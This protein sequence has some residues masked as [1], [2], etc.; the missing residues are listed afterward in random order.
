MARE[1]IEF[2]NIHEMDWQPVSIPG[3]SG[4]LMQKLLS[5][6]EESGA[7]TSL[8]YI[9][10]GAT[11]EG[12]A[13]SVSIE[14]LL[15]E[16]TVEINTTEISDLTHVYI[17]KHVGLNFIQFVSGCTFLWMTE[18]A[19]HLVN[20]DATISDK[21]IVFT[22]T[23]EIPWQGTITPGFPTG[24]MRKSLYQNPETG[25]SSWLLGVLPQF[26]DDRYEIH[27]VMEE[28][29]QIHGEMGTSRG[30]FKQGSYFWRPAEIPHGDF[31]TEWGC[32]TFFR[33]DGPLKTTYVTKEDLV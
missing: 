9:P 22:K 32:L 7:S 6:D 16:G 13:Y 10:S 1:H 17:E 12:G 26:H 8:L 14:A 18:G 24:A 21:E 2:V 30:D 33:T 23:A 19:L 3:F 11:H 27:P 4:E 29:F 31:S 28:A 5:M 20:D 15:L 25:A